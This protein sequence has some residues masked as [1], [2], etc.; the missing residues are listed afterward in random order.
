VELIAKGCP[1][2]EVLKVGFAELTH[3][4]FENFGKMTTL[5]ELELPFRLK[6][7]QDTKRYQEDHPNV[8]LHM[9]PLVFDVHEPYGSWFPAIVKSFTS[10]QTSIHYYGQPDYTDESLTPVQWPERSAEFGTHKNEYGVLE[11]SH[12]TSDCA[13]CEALHATLEHTKFGGRRNV[14]FINDW[15]FEEEE[16]MEAMKPFLEQAAKGQ[17]EISAGD[18]PIGLKPETFM[19]GIFEKYPEETIKQFEFQPSTT[20]EAV[21]Y[22]KTLPHLKSLSY[23]R[24]E[25]DLEEFKKIAEVFPPNLEEF[26]FNGYIKDECAE[27]LATKI[28]NVTALYLNSCLEITEKGLLDLCKE[29]SKLQVLQVRNCEWL[30]PDMLLKI[31]QN[32]KEIVKLNLTI[33]KKLAE[34]AD[35]TI[36]H[37]I[38]NFPALK[39]LSVDLPI[40]KSPKFEEFK[41]AR[42]D[43]VVEYEN[44]YLRDVQDFY[45]N[46]W[47]PA[48]QIS[49]RT[50][51]K[52]QVTYHLY[53]SGSEVQLNPELEDDKQKVKPFLSST[54]YGPQDFH[55]TYY[56]DCTYC[57]LM[58]TVCE[59][60]QFQGS[61]NKFFR[62]IWFFDGEEGKNLLKKI[63]PQGPENRI[64]FDVTLPDGIDSWGVVRALAKELDLQK[65]YILNLPNNSLGRFAKLLEQ[66]LPVVG[67]ELP[68][69]SYPEDQFLEIMSEKV[70]KLTRLVLEQKNFSENFWPKL[71]LPELLYL[72]VS[73]CAS[74][75][76]NVIEGMAKSTKLTH[77]NVGGTGLTD[78]SIT[79]LAK[80]WTNLTNLDLR[81]LA[82][83]EKSVEAIYQ[84]CPNLQSLSLVL[85]HKVPAAACQLISDSLPNLKELKVPFHWTHAADSL[86][87][88]KTARP[89]VKVIEKSELIDA[90][91]ESLNAWFPAVILYETST[92][93][94][95]HYYGIGDD[96]IW[97]P[98]NSPKLAPLFTNKEKYGKQKESHF[99]ATC[100][101]CDIL[102]PICEH[103]KFG[104]S[105]NLAF[106]SDWYFDSSEGR[107]LINQLAGQVKTSGKLD[108][109][110][111]LPAGLSFEKTA[112][113]VIDATPSDLLRHINFPAPVS[114]VALDEILTDKPSLL[115]LS[116]SAPFTDDHA[117]VIANQCETLTNL[118]LQHCKIT[119]VGLASIAAK[120]QSLET[121]V[122]KCC[123]NITNKGVESLIQTNKSL[124][125][126]ELDMMYQIT[127][128]VLKPMAKLPR[129]VTLTLGHYKKPEVTEAI[130]SLKK[131]KPLMAINRGSIVLDCKDI[132]GYWFPA[133]VKEF[134]D[135]NKSFNVHFFGVPD[136]Y[137]SWIEYEANP[138]NVAEAFTHPEEYGSL[139]SQH[140][141]EHCPM[142]KQLQPL[143]KDFLFS[144]NK[145]S[146]YL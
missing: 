65:T 72:D 97:L 115:S 134:N 56:P 113:A 53:G 104:H 138:D 12:T 31:G 3:N 22:L 1:K 74:L 13:L 86:S 73:G 5:K 103:L 106:I 59:N 39:T 119:D 146:A 94:C 114:I 19:K 40:I 139:Y 25:T 117:S 84:N 144:G 101:Y 116:L 142:C 123:N 23:W 34:K 132:S 6:K 43:V 118:V 48:I 46:N 90:L 16:G 2:L 82:I 30:T 71:N 37:L 45:S 17:L 14:H 44:L 95:I 28:P 78:K 4:A 80:E 91:H 35:D 7:H 52:Q 54:N 69:D 63:T 11:Y 129:L 33:N 133:V 126:I 92:T 135:T 141:K 143:C 98:I 76:D 10:T 83:T 81:N 121:L 58:H 96:Y 26:R 111:N 136:S 87:N 32:C 125:T 89:D 9:E 36:V 77:L 88:L 127:A 100:H 130:A 124:D 107:S 29:N 131:K 15:F 75:K 41:S 85:C 120:I 27:L 93:Y 62:N 67:I 38:K 68:K 50:G 128:D 51:P 108:L 99:A 137:D 102:H 61:P 18:T 112:K 145:M 42:P 49:E 122:I 47:Y 64:T 110:V 140:L 8:K 24:T 21:A 55:P 20:D 57:C 60:L 66:P 105:K 70:P 109:A 79:V